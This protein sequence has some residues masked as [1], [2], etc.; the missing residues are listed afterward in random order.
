MKK[1]S[2]LLLT[3]LILACGNRNSGSSTTND[4][5]NAS[6]VDIPEVSGGQNSSLPSGELISVQDYVYDAD[7][8][9]LKDMTMPVINTEKIPDEYAAMYN[10]E[11]KALYDKLDADYS[12]NKEEGSGHGP[13]SGFQWYITGDILSLSLVYDYAG[14]STGSDHYKTFHLDVKTGKPVS[15]DE[16]ISVARLTPADIVN[17]VNAANNRTVINTENYNNY[18][19]YYTN[20]TIE[21]KSDHYYRN[22][23]LYLGKEGLTVYVR[24]TNLPF[25]DGEY[26]I[27]FLPTQWQKQSF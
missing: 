9:N 19:S 26:T 3:L 24:V 14:F 2:Y 16:L 15:A 6:Q 4:S 13:R 18:K 10:S 5:E 8:C 22:L 11:I 7:W 12:R 27:P 21:Y 1:L 17:A 23:T 25:G 20:G